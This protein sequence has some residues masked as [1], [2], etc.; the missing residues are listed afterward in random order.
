MAR[1]FVTRRLPGKALDRLASEHDVDIWRGELPPAPADL[2]ERAG[3]AHG[4]LCLLTDKVDR[5]LL[6]ACPELRAVSNYAVGSD[7]VDVAAATER[8]IP[9]GVTPDVLTETTAD[10]AFGLMIAAAR[11][12]VWGELSVREGDWLTWEPGGWLGR[13][14]HGT[15]LGIIGLG[16]IG[17]AV[18]RRAEGFDM[19][20]LHTS[21]SSGVPLDELLSES[22]FVSI[23][24]P[25]TPD[26]RGL[27]GERELQAM[28]DTSVLVN[29]SRG[30]IIDS[31][32]LQR[33]LEQRWI[34]AA[35]L[36]VTDPEPLPNDHP[37][38]SAPNL[39]VVPHI[40]SATHRTRERMADMAVDNLLAALAGEPMP[41]SA[42]PRVEP[43]R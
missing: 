30:P 7:N 42:N 38:L 9:V 28:K 16:R 17:K 15:T 24:A 19:R 32:A 3:M 33:A 34:E 39:L 26:T 27:I 35:A 41:H 36:D 25:L 37:L 6:D 18:A 8:G 11:H 29:T 4:L 43:R 10:F 2:R 1:C 5:T 40:A 12:I 23:H 31:A 22:D 21:R 20:V 14:V 13:D